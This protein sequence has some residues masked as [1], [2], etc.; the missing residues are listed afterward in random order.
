MFEFNNTPPPAEAQQKRI[1]V[2]LLRICRE[3]SANLRWYLLCESCGKSLC[4]PGRSAVNLLGCLCESFGR[5]LCS[6]GRS[7]LPSIFVCFCHDAIFFGRPPIRRR[8]S[9]DCP[10]DLS[11]RFSRKKSPSWLQ[12]SSRLLQQLPQLSQLPQ[13]LPSRSAMMGS[14]PWEN[15]TRNRDASASSLKNC[16][17]AA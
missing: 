17:C 2:D 8:S 16:S 4:S 3:I 1:G 5:S 7:A 11:S 13:H 12:S 9:E 10:T 15:P 6:P 14:S